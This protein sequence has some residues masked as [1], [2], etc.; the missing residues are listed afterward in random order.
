MK[1]TVVTA[2]ITVLLALLSL[3]MRA[4]DVEELLNE[5][6]TQEEL[7]T[8][9]LND[10]ELMKKF[11]QQLAADQEAMKKMM[12]AMMQNPQH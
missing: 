4:Q 10:E 11:G 1:T 12:S 3:E 2:M 6:A 7:F 8:A 9:I 5:E